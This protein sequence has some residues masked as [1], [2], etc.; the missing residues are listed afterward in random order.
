MAEYT[1]IPGHGKVRVGSSYWTTRPGVGKCQAIA[2][3]PV[4]ARS[5]ETS[6]GE[7]KKEE[8]KN[9]NNQF[10]LQSIIRFL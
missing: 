6:E 10:S 4:V 5:Y 8:T 2:S 1:I 7:N 9:A 3:G